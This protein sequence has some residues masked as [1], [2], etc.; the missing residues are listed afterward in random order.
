MQLLGG[1]DAFAR[2]RW[3]LTKQDD[4]LLQRYKEIGVAGVGSNNVA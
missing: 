4:S 2:V 1:F 3:T